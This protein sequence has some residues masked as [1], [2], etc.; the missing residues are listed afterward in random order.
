MDFFKQRIFIG[1]LCLVS[2]LIVVFHTSAKGCLPL[3]P[4]R[5]IR[6][7]D[8]QATSQFWDYHQHYLRVRFVMLNPA[9]PFPDAAVSSV[10]ITSLKESALPAGTTIRA[11]KGSTRR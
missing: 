7:L 11:N 4:F 9:G 6:D 1:A 3:L 2:L 8:Y 10:A 5:L